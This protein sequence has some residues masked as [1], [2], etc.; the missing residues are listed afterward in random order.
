V[1]ITHLRNLRHP[2]TRTGPPDNRQGS[3]RPTRGAP[4]AASGFRLGRRIG[5]ERAVL[6]A[7]DTLLTDD[8][9]RIAPGL[10]VPA[11]PA[12]GAASETPQPDAAPS[13]VRRCANSGVAAAIATHRIMDGLMDRKIISQD[14]LTGEDL[15]AILLLSLCLLPVVWELASAM[16]QYL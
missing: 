15:I 7:T 11:R 5:G 16:R 13:L 3:P 9:C 6:R 14:R 8:V 2:T 10:G 12:W 4:S 1:S